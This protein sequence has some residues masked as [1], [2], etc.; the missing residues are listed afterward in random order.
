MPQSFIPEHFYGKGY[1]LES[2]I[3]RNFNS[4][5]LV[6]GFRCQYLETQV[7][8]PACLSDVGS[9]TVPTGK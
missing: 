5:F 6:S 1:N 7:L 9:A 8:G 2:G 4:H 3:N